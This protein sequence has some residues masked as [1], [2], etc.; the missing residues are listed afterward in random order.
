MRKEKM[1]AVAEKKK[2][3]GVDGVVDEEK[4]KQ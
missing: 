4:K 2:E 3:N 1:A